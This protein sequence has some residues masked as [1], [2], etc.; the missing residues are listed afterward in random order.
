MNPECDVHD[1]NLPNETHKQCV[2]SE[3]MESVKMA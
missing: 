1:K 2:D 3:E